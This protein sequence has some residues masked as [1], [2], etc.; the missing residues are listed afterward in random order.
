[1]VPFTSRPAGSVP[2]WT[3]PR[4][5]VLDTASLAVYMTLCRVCHAL[6]SANVRVVTE[7]TP[8]NSDIYLDSGSFARPSAQTV[9]SFMQASR[10]GWADSRQVHHPG[11]QARAL[12]EGCREAVAGHLGVGAG[13]VRFAPSFALAVGNGIGGILAARRRVGTAAVH[14]AVEKAVV[15][16]SAEFHG[17]QTTSIGVDSYG[18]A[19]VEAWAEA[20]NTPG[21]GLALAQHA[22][23]ETGVLQPLD[24]LS[25]AAKSARVPLMVDAS[26]AF[27]YAL[28]DAVW[29][30]LVLDATSWGVP[31]PLGVL[32]TQPRTRWQAVWPPDADP[33]FPGG[34]GTAG[35][36]A[37]AVALEQLLSERIALQNR[38]EQF[39]KLIATGL[40][41]ELARHLKLLP[42]A[43]QGGLRHVLTI[44]CPAIDGET[45]AIA[46]DREGISVGAGSACSAS[47][48]EPSHV[49]RAMG[50]DATGSIRLGFDAQTTVADV[51]AFLEALPRALASIREMFGNG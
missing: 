44:L 15:I 18:L 49:L 45:L 4:T 29:D 2:L 48:L 12:L 37:A 32:V 8:S 41:G 31:A 42:V 28:P 16:N 40:E 33:W 9:E 50:A 39:R 27:P 47:A 51:N 5:F 6:R 3:L 36:L 14:L 24:Q 25:Q 20:V 13:Q 46:L 11:R 21:I 19:D 10:Q 30:A 17:S 7:L 35:V 22:N 43:P 23:Q 38:F 34:V 26:S 1:M